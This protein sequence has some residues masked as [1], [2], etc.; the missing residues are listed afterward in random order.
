V[1][2]EVE[3]MDVGKQEFIRDEIIKVEQTLSAEIESL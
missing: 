3:D 2:E 1:T